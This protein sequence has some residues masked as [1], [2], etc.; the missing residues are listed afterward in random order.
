MP[1]LETT[2]RARRSGVE[3]GRS[4]SRDF[5]SRLPAL[6]RLAREALFGR[7]KHDHS[8][9]TPAP[10]A[11]SSCGFAPSAP[12][13]AALIALLS[14]VGFTDC[15]ECASF[16]LAIRGSLPASSARPLAAPREVAGYAPSVSRTCFP[17]MVHGTF[18]SFSFST[19]SASVPRP[20]RRTSR[21]LRFLHLGGVLAEPISQRQ[22][23]R[24]RPVCL[25]AF[26]AR[27]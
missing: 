27:T 4:R 20:P 18:R 2:D 8:S 26:G 23:H 13:P 5:R 1:G 10:S 11:Q 24:P 21:M 7:R 22:F 25:G 15:L 12:R 14:P 16:N 6:S 19:P 3:C 17:T 9:R